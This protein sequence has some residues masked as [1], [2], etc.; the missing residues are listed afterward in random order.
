VG[1]QRGGEVVGE[2]GWGEGRG[3]EEKKRWEW[4]RELVEGGGIKEG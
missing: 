4:K 2:R 1:G 3:E